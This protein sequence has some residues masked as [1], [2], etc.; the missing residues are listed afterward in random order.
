RRPEDGDGAPR[1]FR[2]PGHDFSVVALS[3]L[4]YLLNAPAPGRM[5][6]HQTPFALA[7]R[8]AEDAVAAAWAA[9]PPALRA[10]AGPDF[11]ARAVDAL[12]G[13]RDAARAFGTA[14]G[15]PKKLTA[16]DWVLVAALAMAV[17]FLFRPYP[18][19]AA[20]ATP[21]PAA[22][23]VRA[24]GKRSAAGSGGGSTSSASESKGSPVPPALPPK[25]PAGKSATEPSP[26]ATPSKTSGGSD[27]HDKKKP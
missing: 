17:G 22:A 11:A 20:V 24:S 2:Y 25:T 13:A 27:R 4:L 15:M 3:T 7:L 18:A 16:E 12:R 10:T 8:A 14:I 9:A 26:K 1:P 23:A 5:A 6:P 21:A 19:A